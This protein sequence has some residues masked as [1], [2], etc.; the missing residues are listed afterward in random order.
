M[1]F[2]L[3][4]LCTATLV[5]ASAC[6]S[7]TEPTDAASEAGTCDGP[8]SVTYTCEPRSDDGPGCSGT[9][10]T[11]PIAVP[12]PDAVFPVGCEIIYPGCNPYYPSSFASCTCRDDDADGSP[13][14]VCP[15]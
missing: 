7:S 12:D 5:L 8:A 1:R 10:A 3:R 15:I 4:G 6:S 13:D 14:W 11:Y 2:L 9:T